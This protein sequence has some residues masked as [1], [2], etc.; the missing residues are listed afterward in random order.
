M[1][2]GFDDGAR[3]LHLEF[4]GAGELR[5]GQHALSTPHARSSDPRQLTPKFQLQHVS[6]AYAEKEPLSR[7]TEATKSSCR[8]KARAVL[9]IARSVW[10]ARKTLV[11][12]TTSRAGQICMLTTLDGLT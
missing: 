12:P 2:H 4:L 8:G 9:A 5:Q 6:L 11:Q 1:E 7:L 10:I 3:I